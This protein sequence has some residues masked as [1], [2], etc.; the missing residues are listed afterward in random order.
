MFCSTGKA[1]TLILCLLVA[2]GVVAAQGAGAR[3]LSGVVVTAREVVVP[4]VTVSVNASGGVVSV[5]S[6]AEGRFRLVVPAGSLMLRLTGEN[7]SPV[8]RQFAANDATE[9]PRLQIVDLG[10]N[11]RLRRN[12]DFNLAI[13]NLFNKRYY[14]T[15]NF[16]E[17]RVCPGDDPAERVH[18]TPGYPFDVTIGV[19]F[20]P[21]G[22]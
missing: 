11:K 6:D 7:V 8:T 19:T 3:V 21:G 2:S 12:L 9:N 16:F 1:F 10:V 4:G 5:V 20:R 14:E 22:K 15:Q 13:D 17:S 18:A